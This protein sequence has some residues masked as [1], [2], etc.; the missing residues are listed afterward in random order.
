MFLF[1][2]NL[3]KKASSSDNKASAPKCLRINIL[4]HGLN[5]FLNRTQVSSMNA[6]LV[7]SEMSPNLG[8]EANTLNITKILFNELRSSNKPTRSNSRQSRFYPDSHFNCMF[9]GMAS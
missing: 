6:T 4:S 8:H 3:S 9:V 2:Y 1:N 7:L 5:S